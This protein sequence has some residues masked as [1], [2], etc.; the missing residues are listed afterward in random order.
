MLGIEIYNSKKMNP[1]ILLATIGFF[2]LVGVFIVSFVL[3]PEVS[4]VAYSA[5]LQRGSEFEWDFTGITIPPEHG[6]PVLLTPVWGQNSAT[7]SGKNI[8]FLAQ[9]GGEVSLD[10]FLTSQ[11]VSKW[12]TAKQNEFRSD[13][14]KVQPSELEIKSSH[15]FW[16]EVALLYVG[17][18]TCS[19]SDSIFLFLPKSKRYMVWGP[20]DKSVILH[21]NEGVP[22]ELSGKWGNPPDYIL[23]S[24]PPIYDTPALEIKL[25]STPTT[26]KSAFSGSGIFIHVRRDVALNMN[27]PVTLLITSGN[28]FGQLVFNG[29]TRIITPEDC[30]HLSYSP[31]SPGQFWVDISNRKTT[32]IGKALIVTINGRDA[33]PR[34]L[35]TWPWWIQWIFI[36]LIG[37]IGGLIIDPWR[38]ILTKN[39]GNNV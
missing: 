18:L 8:R 12:M 3:R 33:R 15:S 24:D 16:V 26:R 21:K 32:I 13:K 30:L 35:E 17:N 5:N 20:T 23:P 27:L 29:K 38:Q 1:K 37:L 10:L 25:E 2:F 34:M 9:K 11:T 31:A 19:S 14:T 36:G 39:S 7:L 4:A 6:E 28:S 22:L